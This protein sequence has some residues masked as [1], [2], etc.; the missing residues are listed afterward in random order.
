[1]TTKV[2]ITG[3]DGQ[4]GSYLSELLLTK[5][6][7]V[8]GLLRRNV[9]APQNILHIKDKLHL[10]YGDMATENHLSHLLN[11]L[12]PE[13]VYNLAGQSDVMLSF[14]IPE[15]TGDVTGLGVTRLLEAVRKFSPK[16]KVYLAGSS[17]QFGNAHAPQN[18][19]TPMRA[20]SPYSA[21][22]IYAYNMGIV[23]R[24]AYGLFICNGILF[25]HESQ[26]RGINFVTRK[27]S[28]AVARIYLGL[29]DKLELGNLNSERDWGYSPDFCEAMFLMLQQNKP[30]DFVIGTGFKHT[31][32][33]F[34]ATAFNR[35][36]M[37]YSKYVIINTNLFR[38]A[39]A[40]CLQ[41]DASKARQILG[42]Q[43]T[44]TFKQLVATMVDSDLKL[45]QREVKDIRK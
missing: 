15:Y 39:D 20:R 45:A 37:D 5:D 44:T 33:E 18:E 29:Q 25:N 26:R 4:D 34:A 41:A 8:H 28:M 30:D 7:E 27:I 22:K 6:Y 31:V 43:P 40:N 14:E 2:L 13:E 3:I 11:E 35:L 38:P 24:E 12:Q 17:E 16:S 32:R 9:N 36:E 23:Y 19:K 1:M 10:H 42:W 21:S